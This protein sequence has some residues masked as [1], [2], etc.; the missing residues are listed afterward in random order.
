MADEVSEAQAA[1]ETAESSSTTL[2]RLTAQLQA[3]ETKAK[4]AT[5][6]A[7]QSKSGHV[8]VLSNVGSLGEGVLK[9]CMSRHVDPHEA[10][11]EMAKEATPL[12]KPEAEIL[13]GVQRSQGFLRAFEAVMFNKGDIKAEFDKWNQE[14]QEAIK[15]L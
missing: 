13:T 15:E 9:I 6:M 11:R 4:Q 14:V 8:L 7:R 10:V 12:V 2:K 3:I 5:S 1:S